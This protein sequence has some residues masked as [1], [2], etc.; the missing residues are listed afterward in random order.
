MPKQIVVIVDDQ[1]EQEKLGGFPTRFAEHVRELLTSRPRV[2]ETREL[3]K[4]RD[5]PAES[6]R[7]R[8]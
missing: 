2:S 3:T 5:L 8:R 7:V 1:P 6:S 4:P